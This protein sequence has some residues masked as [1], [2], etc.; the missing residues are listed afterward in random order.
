MSSFNVLPRHDGYRSSKCAV[1]RFTIARTVTSTDFHDGDDADNNDN[2]RPTIFVCVCGMSE[3]S[4]V[5]EL[6]AGA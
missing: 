5:A 6:C 4:E 1:A 2:D 3:V